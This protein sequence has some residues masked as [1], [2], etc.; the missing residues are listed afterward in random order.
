MIQCVVMIN[1]RKIKTGIPIPIP[2]H[3]PIQGILYQETV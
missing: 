3:I 1:L 2:I